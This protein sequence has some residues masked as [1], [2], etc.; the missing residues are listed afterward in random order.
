MKTYCFKIYY[1]EMDFTDLV[2]VG[3][4]SPKEAISSFKKRYGNVDFDFLGE[5]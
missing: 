5:E 3:A 1:D 4:N 2:Y